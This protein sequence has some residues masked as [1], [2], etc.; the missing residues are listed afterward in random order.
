MVRRLL[1]VGLR[2]ILFGLASGLALGIGVAWAVE[3]PWGSVVFTGAAVVMALLGVSELWIY[4]RRRAGKAI[5]D[6]LT[7]EGLEKRLDLFQP[8]GE[9]ADVDADAQRCWKRADEFYL[10]VE[11]AV[12]RYADDWHPKLKTWPREHAIYKGV[13]KQRQEVVRAYDAWLGALT[14]IR[15]K[16]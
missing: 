3:N 2:G 16:L 5:F 11:T 8:M 12:H 13:P 7:D 6:A 9:D 15:T 14:E 4:F 1:S 10:R